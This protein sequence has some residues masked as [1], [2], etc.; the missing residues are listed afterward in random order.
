M[1]SFLPSQCCSTLSTLYFFIV[2]NSDRNKTDKFIHARLVTNTDTAADMG[3]N[4]QNY[5]GSSSKLDLPQVDLMNFRV[6]YVRSR[7]SRASDE[8]A[9]GRPSSGGY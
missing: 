5:L 4:I 9:S 7:S 8:V 6:E 3:Q 1:F 2:G